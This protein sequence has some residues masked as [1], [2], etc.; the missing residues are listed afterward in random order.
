M[1]QSNPNSSNTL[2]INNEETIQK[3][4]NLDNRFDLTS[5]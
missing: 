3:L 2:S 5:G 1:N 4:P